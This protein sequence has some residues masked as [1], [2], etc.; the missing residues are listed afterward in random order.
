MQ[1]PATQPPPSC[2]QTALW[3]LA[4]ATTSIVCWIAYVA[5]K[6]LDHD[7]V[8]GDVFKGGDRAR[9]CVPF[10]GAPTLLHPPPTHPRRMHTR[11]PPSA[12]QFCEHEGLP[13]GLLHHRCGAPTGP[14]PC[15]MLHGAALHAAAGLPCACLASLVA[16]RCPAASAPQQPA[17][18]CARQAWQL[19]VALLRRRRRRAPAACHA[20]N[21]PLQIRCMCTGT[22]ALAPLLQPHACSLLAPRPPQGDF[23]L[24]LS[25]DYM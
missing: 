6:E 19:V 12:A 25:G 23:M 8:S 18:S 3:S 11:H 4:S 10:S 20:T 13:G 17:A 21:L 1:L 15:R 14:P 7:G 24:M 5:Y 2:T 22:V 16:A 9:G